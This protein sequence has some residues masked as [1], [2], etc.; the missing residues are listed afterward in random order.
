MV[1][2]N[3]A[4]TTF[5]FVFRKRENRLR[6]YSDVDDG[7][8]AI[9]YAPGTHRKGRIRK[10]PESFLENGVR[11]W[12]DE[13]MDA[14]VPEEKWIKGAGPKGAIV[15]ADTRGYHKGGLARTSDRI[16]YTCMF[17]NRFRRIGRPVRI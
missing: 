2:S 6:Y 16:L 1:C 4:Y 3:P 11:R 9:T 8:G 10:I 15:F 5:Q 14:V 17:T 7:A 12:S 13:Q